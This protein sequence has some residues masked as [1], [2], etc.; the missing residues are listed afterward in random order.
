M[1]ALISF[2]G[3]EGH[4]Q[5]LIPLALAAS[6]AGHEVTVSGAAAL[7]P[8]AAAS[9]LA[10]VASG[11]DA[12]SQRVPLQ[13]VDMAREERGVREAF[14]GR[15]ARSRA[16]DLLALCVRWRPDVVV[17]DEMDFGAAVVAE[18]LSIP[19]ASV[20]VIAAGGFVRPD[21]VAEALDRLRAEYRLPPDPGL[22]MLSRYL[23]LCPFPPSYRDPADP[24]P[25]TAHPFGSSAAP[26]RPAAEPLIERRGRRRTVYVTLGTIVNTESGDLFPRVLAGVRELPVEVVVTV[27]RGM[28]PGELG[29]Q[30]PNVHVTRYLPR[31]EV[32]PRCAAAVTH[33][34]S[35]SVIGALAH[36]V[37]L[38][39]IPIGADQP[40]NARRCTALGV[41]RALDAMTA[42]A[43]QV[44][45]AVSAVLIEPGYR[46][47]AARLQA[48]IAALPAPAAAVGLLERLALERSPLPVADSG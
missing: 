36:G 10:F 28:D 43:E 6:A 37:P 30:P 35:G 23:V 12:V 40:L 11:P 46:H 34:G 41:G 14:A 18:H 15:V 27:G 32:L 48:E 44:R 38:V 22:A 26:V 19:H 8:V 21:V 3:G 1:R 42:T 2:V 5:P 16:T 7:A 9:G 24:L 47:A 33:A 4:L 17:R 20:L 13:P 29:I 25:A 31:S 39:C 45:E